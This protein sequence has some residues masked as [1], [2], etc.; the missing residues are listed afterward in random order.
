[1]CV[2]GLG[3]VYATRPLLQPASLLE[4][5]PVPDVLEVGQLLLPA[6]PVGVGAERKPRPR[7]AEQRRQRLSDAIHGL[8]VFCPGVVLWVEQPDQ[9]VV[10]DE[11][12]LLHGGSP[13]RGRLERRLHHRSEGRA[14]VVKVRERRQRQIDAKPVAIIVAFRSSSAR[15]V[16]IRDLLIHILGQGVH[17]GQPLLKRGRLRGLVRIADGQQQ[18]QSGVSPVAG[19][20]DCARGHLHVR[21]GGRVEGGVHDDDA[22]R[23]SRF[24]SL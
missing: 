24:A 18:Q 21:A 15:L 4:S 22:P 9:G 10:A 19:A 1:M 7:A 2:P 6:A 13:R 8:S 5:V 14:L 23:Q 3:N 11:K 12:H 17:H 16:V 20:A